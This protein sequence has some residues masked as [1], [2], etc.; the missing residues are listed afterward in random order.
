[1]QYAELYC[2]GDI[3][4][5]RVGQQYTYEGPQLVG[6]VTVECCYGEVGCV[7]QVD[8]WPLGFGLTVFAIAAVVMG[9]LLWLIL[10]RWRHQEPVESG[11]WRVQALGL[12]V[13]IGSVLIVPLGV[14]GFVRGLEPWVDVIEGMVL[15]V[16]VGTALLIAVLTLIDV[17]L[18]LSLVRVGGRVRY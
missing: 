5:E 7:D 18:Y 17:I 6:P 12:F 2:S 1:M 14:Y 3:L 10:I 4:P 8:T 16:T 15:R 11:W 9:F 13:A